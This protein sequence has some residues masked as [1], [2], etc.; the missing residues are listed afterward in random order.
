MRSILTIVLL[1]SAIFGVNASPNLTQKNRLLLVGGALKTCSSQSLKN[2]NSP[3]SEQVS[4]NNDH[5]TTALYRVDKHS[6]QRLFDSWPAHVAKKHQHGLARLF[7]KLAAKSDGKKLTKNELRDLWRQYDDKKRIKKLPDPAYYY[8]LDTLE[9]KVTAADGKTRLKEQVY[10]NQG[11]NPFA[12]ELYRDFVQSAAT[13]S[14]KQKPNILVVT[15]SSRDPF[16]AVD[17]YTQVFAQ[18][19]GNTQWLPV[20]ATLQATWQLSG[21]HKQ[22]CAQLAQTRLTVQGSAFRESVYP[23]LTE[24]Q[25]QACLSPDSVIKQIEWADGIFFNG[26]DQSLT[27]QAFKDATGEDYPVMAKIRE[28]LGRNQLVA[29][30]TSAGTAVM[31]GGLFENRTLPMISNGYSE[32]A[33]NRGAKADKLPQEGCHKSNSCA[34]DLLD[35][36]LTYRSKGGLA[37]F[38]WGIMDT[39]FSER[40]RQGRLAQ[41][42]K[43]TNTRFAFGVDETTALS[44]S[45]AD[46]QSDQPHFEVKGQSGV[47][48]VQNDGKTLLTHYLTRG[49]R[50]GLMSNQLNI[51]FAP[52]KQPHQQQADLPKNTPDLFVEDKYK[53]LAKLLCSTQNQQLSATSQWR[54]QHNKITI[55]KTKTSAGHSGGIQLAGRT[56]RYCSY[57][58]YSLKMH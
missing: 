16:E 22:K 51:A 27:V 57:K 9:V 41:L 12:I 52:W 45:W 21:T 34:D 35:G 10:L 49:D 1:T 19:G 26:G 48:V 42:A 30:G 43:D 4:A 47:Y 53:L 2:C 6:K 31:S 23:D 55:S 40:G 5:K 58:N 3:F 56:F 13:I 18:A 33:I 39:H 36:D 50:A 11:K 7:D 38:R 54:R 17:F 24:Q 37:L 14:G 25:Y 29:G 32:V 8:L 15:A 20:D 46:G 44:V 28:K